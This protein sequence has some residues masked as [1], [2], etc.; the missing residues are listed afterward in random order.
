MSIGYFTSNGNWCSIQQ[1]ADELRA[2]IADLESRPI[3][4]F[5]IKTEKDAVL[6]NVYPQLAVIKDDPVMIKNRILDHLY[7]IAN[8]LEKTIN[9]FRAAEEM[10]Y[11]TYSPAGFL[12]EVE[13]PQNENL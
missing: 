10:S 1:A 9:G 12:Y 4:D 13:K 3:S 6:M 11:R 7:G 2:Y 5:E 8:T